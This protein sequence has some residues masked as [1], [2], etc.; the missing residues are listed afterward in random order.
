MW[1]FPQPYSLFWQLYG[2]LVS[3]LISAL[4]RKITNALVNGFSCEVAFPGQQKNNKV[5][6]PMNKF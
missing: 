3:V 5:N 6:E 1:I 4:T 2:F